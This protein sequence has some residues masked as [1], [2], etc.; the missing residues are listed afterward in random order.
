MKNVDKNYTMIFKGSA[1]NA[2]LVIA[3]L[4]SNGIKSAVKLSNTDTSFKTGEDVDRVYV[5]AKEVDNAM[6][7]LK[8]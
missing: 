2:D 8:D 7:L 1:I 5:H 4:K 3:K 6:E